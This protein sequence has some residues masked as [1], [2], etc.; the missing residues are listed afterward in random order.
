M[1]KPK[2]VKQKAV[3]K[4]PAEQKT[5]KQYNG[6]GTKKIELVRC[7]NA[8]VDKFAAETGMQSDDLET[9]V[10]DLVSE[11]MHLCKFN[12]LDFEAIL[13]RSREC[14]NEELVLGEMRD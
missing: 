8:A 14:F 11:L 7:P 6:R 3:A 10:C 9:R 12:G 1:P 2:P 4:T 13:P 5:V